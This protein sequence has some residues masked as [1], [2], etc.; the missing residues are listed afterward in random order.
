MKVNE[1]VVYVMKGVDGIANH[2]D[3]SVEE[4]VESLKLILRY[5][6]AA[7]KDVFKRRVGNRVVAY[8]KNL[9]SAVTGK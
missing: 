4:V 6:T 8:F 3:A 9:V 1:K 2:D 7:I 5:V